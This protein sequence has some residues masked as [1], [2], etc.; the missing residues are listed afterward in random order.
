MFPDTYEPPTGVLITRWGK[1]PFSRGAYA[2]IKAGAARNAYS[3]LAEP[4]Q[5]KVS[6]ATRPHQ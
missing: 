3:V 1:D 4:V 6:A 5:G 2:Y